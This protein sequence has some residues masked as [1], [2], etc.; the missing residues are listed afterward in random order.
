MEPEAGAGVWHRALSA[1][2]PALTHPGQDPHSCPVGL[3]ALP[4]CGGE[5]GP[6]VGM[7]GA[8]AQHQQVARPGVGGRAWAPPCSLAA[9]NGTRRSPGCTRPQHLGQA[10]AG[11]AVGMGYQGRSRVPPPLPPAKERQ[12]ARGRRNINFIKIYQ[13]LKLY[14]GR[15]WRGRRGPGPSTV[16]LTIRREEERGH[17]WHTGQ[18]TGSMQEVVQL[19][20]GWGGQGGW[21]AGRGAHRVPQAP[22]Q[23]WHLPQPLPGWQKWGRLRCQWSLSRGRW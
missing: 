15:H 21:G 7:P 17:H 5:L 19:R 20:V 14:T 18:G 13:T 11:S 4:S 9:G 2:P 16:L 1:G 12:P 23:R 22:T 8:S 3:G 6:A 10:W